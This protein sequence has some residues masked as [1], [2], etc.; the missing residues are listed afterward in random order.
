MKCYN[1]YVTCGKTAKIRSSIMAKNPKPF[2]DPFKNI[3]L[4]DTQW[5]IFYF[6]ILG[7]GIFGFIF[8]TVGLWRD[9]K[10]MM[11]SG[12]GIGFFAVIVMVIV[13]YV[14]KGREMNSK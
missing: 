10:W 11:F 4:N 3:H 14:E 1:T 12:A 8:M 7:I 6:S 2:K 9:T 13:M 5:Y